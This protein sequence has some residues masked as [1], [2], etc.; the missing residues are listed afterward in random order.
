MC[1]LVC[2]TS[3][4]YLCSKHELHFDG[5]DQMA[6]GQEFRARA[7]ESEKPMFILQLTGFMTNYLI[8]TNLVLSVAKW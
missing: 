1:E 4:L 2:T 7:L 8:C 3:V 6:M 5:M